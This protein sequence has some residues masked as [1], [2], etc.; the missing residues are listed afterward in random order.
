LACIAQLGGVTPE[1]YVRRF[2]GGDLLAH[3]RG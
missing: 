1:D 2:G 3:T